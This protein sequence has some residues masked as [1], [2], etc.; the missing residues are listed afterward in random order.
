MQWFWSCRW[1]PASASAAFHPSELILDHSKR[2][3]ARVDM[4][5]ITAKC[6]VIFIPADEVV[7]HDEI[8]LVFYQ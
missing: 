3:D 6:V 2:I 4:A 5:K 1:F 7:P 8:G